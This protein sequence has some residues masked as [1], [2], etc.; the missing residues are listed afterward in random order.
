[1]TRAQRQ[2]VTAELASSERQAASVATIE[3]S[4][5]MKSNCP[6]YGGEHVVRNGATHGLQRCKYRGCRNISALTATPLARLRMKGKWLGQTAVLRGGVTITQAAATLGVA[7][8][9]AFCWRHCFLALPKTIQAKSL[10]GIVETDE[11]YFLQ[12]FKGMCKGLTRPAPKRGG[13]A[14]KQGTSKEQVPV[15]VIRDTR[16]QHCRRHPAGGR[17]SQRRRGA[18]LNPASLLASA[19]RI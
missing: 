11:P 1:M 6:H 18:G 7:R 5:G 3:G 4:G 16:R 14:A 8:S 17:Q 15:L 10:V 19:V 12:S 9:T 2:K 13:S